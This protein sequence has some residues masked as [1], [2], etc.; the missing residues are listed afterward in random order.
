MLYIDELLKSGLKGVSEVD[1]DL[2]LEKVIVIFRYIQD[3][4][5]F[6][7]FYKQHLAKRLLSGRSVSEDAE[8][9]MI[10]KLKV[11]ARAEFRRPGLH[12]L[13]AHLVCT[14]TPSLLADGVRLSVYVEVGGHVHG[15]EHFQ[16]DHGP[17]PGRAAG[18][19]SATQ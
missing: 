12:L 18:A 2:Q 16:D 6:E 13:T 3:K 15:H 14:G 9:S 1:A 5:I 17:V 8:K 10:S 11:H 19:E 4:D 7:N